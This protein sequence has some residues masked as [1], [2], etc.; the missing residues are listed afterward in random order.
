MKLITGLLV[1]AFALGA[2]SQEETIM[3]VQDELAH[4]HRFFETLM[5]L[6]RGQLS[7]YIYRVSRAVLDSHMDTYEFIYTNGAEARNTI[8]NLVPQTPAQEQCID[9]W[10]RRFE[11]QKQR[12]GQRLARCVGHVNNIL[13]TWNSFVNNLHRDGQLKTAQ[14]QNIGFNLFARSS[15]YDGSENFAALMKTDLRDVI[16][17]ALGL[18]GQVEEFVNNI[19]IDIENIEFDFLKCDKDLEADV[20]AEIA[21]ELSGAQACVGG[22]SPIDPDPSQQ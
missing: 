9:Q 15:V 1:F 14:I 21:F 12:F 11:L 3:S 6:N 22:G 7:S 5:G 4:T 17:R 19:S 2:Y 10:R 16:F 8:N 13:L 18:V 20:V